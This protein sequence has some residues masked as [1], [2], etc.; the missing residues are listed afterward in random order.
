MAATP[1]R[2]GQARQSQRRRALCKIVVDGNDI[3]RAVDPH[4]LSVQTVARLGT[5]NEADTATIELDD[6]DGRLAIPPPKAKIEISLGWMNESLGLVWTGVVEEV[7][8]GFSRRGGARRL[9]LEAKGFDWYALKK[10]HFRAAW[11]DG[12]GNEIPL[13]Q[14]LKDAGS[15]AGL[16]VKVAPSMRT[17]SRKYWQQ[18]ESFLHFGW[19]LARELGGDF[20][21][22]GT[23]ATMVNATDGQNVDGQEM[24]TV[25][26]NW[27]ENLLSWRIK[28]FTAAPQAGKAATVVYNRDKGVWEQYV[29]NVKGELP[30]DQSEAIVSLPAP[31]ANR[32]TAEQWNVG[33]EEGALANRGIGSVVINGEPAVQIAGKLNIKGARAGVDGL[34][35]IEEIEHVYSR[36]AG[37]LTTLT[38]RHPE[39]FDGPGTYT[40]WSWVKKEASPHRSA[41]M[42]WETVTGGES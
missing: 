19:R 33:L 22:T 23:V 37:F 17:I 9:W 40:P 24:E 7:E 41:E 6:R 28:P 10:A 32:V 5:K 16:S 31:A 1:E 3:T 39:F 21:I 4:L 2:N 18:N 12:E 38:L 15:A 29:K 14:V 30:F 35:M 42:L 13:E 36:T 25:D 11:G 34:Y 8:S 26:A 20:K 27:G